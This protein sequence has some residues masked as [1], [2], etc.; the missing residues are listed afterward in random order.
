MTSIQLLWTAISN[1]RWDL[2]GQLITDGLNLGFTNGILALKMM[3][4]NFATWLSQLFAD[5]MNDVS[6]KVVAGLNQIV[7]SMRSVLGDS[8]LVRTGLAVFQAGAA[9]VGNAAVGAAQTGSRFVLGSSPQESID[10]AARLARTMAEIAALNGEAGKRAGIGDGPGG[11][12][13][14]LHKSLAI[15]SAI[16]ATSSAAA[17]LLGRS[18][19]GNSIED[20]Q[21]DAQL[22]GNEKLDELIGVVGGLEGL[23][24]D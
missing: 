16:G 9:G 18:A 20:K 2:A 14:Q 15:S 8:A 24:A 19:P 4:V 21:L 7:A 11:I 22:A 23:T 1:G 13:G 17:A 3:W 6:A 10:A 12:A 5:V